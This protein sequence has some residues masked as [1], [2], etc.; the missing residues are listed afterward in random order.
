MPQ[1]TQARL[2]Q[3]VNYDPVTGSFTWLVRF[4]VVAGKKAGH[5]TNDYVVIGIDKRLYLAHRLAWLYTFGELPEMLDHIDGNK[6]NNR[7]DNLRPCTKSTNGANSK[8]NST[9]TSGFKGV[10]WDR[11]TKKWRAYVKKNGRRFHLGLFDNIDDAHRA[12]LAGAED[13]FGNFMRAA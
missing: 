6:Q 9:N 4:G 10:S 1:L 2:R 12:Y 11:D 7:I 8:R 3:V 5:S 13:K